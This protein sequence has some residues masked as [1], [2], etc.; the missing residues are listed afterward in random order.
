MRVFYIIFFRHIVILEKNE[1]LNLRQDYYD[2]ANPS[3]GHESIVSNSWKWDV[4][5]GILLSLMPSTSSIW[6]TL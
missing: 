2:T 1:I 4:S 5:S 3:I 6:N